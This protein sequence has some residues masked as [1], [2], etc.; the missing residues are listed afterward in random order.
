MAS[1]FSR[2][3]RSL[4]SE[5]STGSMLGVAV[6]AAVFALW[7]AWFVSAE[8]PIYAT[9]AEARLEVERA[10]HEV[11]ADAAGRIVEVRAA[12]GQKVA[13]GDVLFELDAELERR[14]LDEETARRDAL[15]KEIESLKTV[16]VT[17]SQGLGDAR[18]VARAALAEARSRYQA[19]VA[20]AELAEE[21]AKRAAQLHEQGLT[22]E[23]ELRR[24]EALARER[25]AQADAL[26]RAVDRGDSERLSERRDRRVRIDQLQRELAELEGSAETSAAAARRLEEEIG[27]RQIRSPAAGRLG[28]VAKAR[29]GS[30]VAAG[31]HLATVIPIA[32]LKVVAGFPPSDALARV[33]QGQPAQL[34][35]DGFPWTEFGSLA[36]EVTRVSGEARDGKLWIDGSVVPGPESAIPLQHGMPGTLVVEVERVSPAELVLRAAGRAVTA[37]DRSD[38]RGSE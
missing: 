30:V 11:A 24:A 10:V 1:P 3:L 14:R 31:D 28:E 38:R 17:E 26:D 8:L 21:E 6:A 7:T 18:Q 13:A 12:V 4:R 9:S 5:R 27:R 19:E 15:L 16:L 2:T 34:R 37:S 22:S 20:A 35:L 23:M 36:S 33:R 29:A 25:R 32:E